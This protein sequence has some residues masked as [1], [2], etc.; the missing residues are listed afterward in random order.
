MMGRALAGLALASSI[1]WVARHAG[2]LSRSGA[3]A[4]VI[5]GTLSVAGSW[6]WGA[7][8]IWFF[9]GSS[10]LTRWRGVVKATRTRGIVEKAGARDAVQVMANGVI[11]AL[12]GALAAWQ[13]S[14]T[15]QTFGLGSLATAAADTFATE[16]GTALRASPRL[17][18]S[19]RRVA[20]GTSGAVSGIGTLASL[21]GGA[22]I[23]GAAL[24]MGWPPAVAISVMVAGIIGAFADTLL[25]AT[26]QER[27]RC[28]DCHQS[29]EALVHDCGATTSRTGGIRGFRNDLVNLTSG[30]LGGLVAVAMIQVLQ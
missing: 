5:V 2:A 10:M 11:F 16:V 12:S 13:G 18:L 21:L 1:A 7:L 15:W 8:L 26:V 9:V 4:S 23:G 25:G 6:R 22:T 14:M 30:A 20:A 29:T 3:V 28:Q 17:I 24:A 19:G 27:R